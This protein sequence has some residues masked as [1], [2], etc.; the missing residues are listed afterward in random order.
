MSTHCVSENEMRQRAE[1]M[2]P[3]DDPILETA[4]DIGN[5]TPGLLADE[6]GYSREHCTKR[7]RELLEYGLLEYVHE[8]SGL[9][10]LTDDGRAYLYESLDA[11]Q[12]TRNKK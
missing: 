4:S 3:A 7:C 12:I 10:R 9:Y 8:P 11:T 6:T 5:V 1:W 2:S